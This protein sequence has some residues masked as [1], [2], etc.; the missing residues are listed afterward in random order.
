LGGVEEE[1]GER[2][3]WVAALLEDVEEEE[4]LLQDT[5]YRNLVLFAP[6]LAEVSL[7]LSL[8]VSLSLSLSP[9]PS[10]PPP[11]SLSH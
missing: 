3:R 4:V 9:P 6:H 5:L 2:Y 11:L 10:P 8:S 1:W 7:S